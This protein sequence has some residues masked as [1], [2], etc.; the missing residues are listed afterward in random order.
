[1]MLNTIHAS[2]QHQQTCCLLLQEDMLAGLNVVPGQ[3]CDKKHLKEDLDQLQSSGLFAG[4]TARV[5]AA[6]PGSKRMRVDIRFAEEI[7]PEIKSLSVSLRPC[8]T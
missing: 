1:M 3:I 5:V 8:E 2:M 7:Y 4:V 6:S